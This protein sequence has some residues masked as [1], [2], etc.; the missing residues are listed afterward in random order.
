VIPYNVLFLPETPAYDDEIES[1]NAEAFG[2][3]RFAKAAYRIREG[4][5][6]ERALSFVATLDDEVIASVR[7]TRASADT[8]ETLLLGPL[9]VRPR[10]K[11]LGIGRRLLAISVEAARKAGHHSVVLV[12]DEPYYGPLGFKHIASGQLTLPRPVDPGRL[13]GHEMTPGALAN[14][15]GRLDHADRRR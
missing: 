12:G 14:L 15:T 4:G 1:I 13:L 2:P 11:N 10:Y 8:G 3:G 6:H 7:L 5:P 9:A